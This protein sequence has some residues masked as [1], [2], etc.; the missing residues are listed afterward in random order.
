MLFR[1]VSQSRYP[2]FEVTFKG[3]KYVVFEDNNE[4]IRADDETEEV[5]GNWDPVKKTI[6]FV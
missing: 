5:I 1:S 2:T 6:V 3:V 4:V